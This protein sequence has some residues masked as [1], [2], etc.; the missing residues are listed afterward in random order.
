MKLTWTKPFQ[1]DYR[2]LPSKTQKIADK[3]LQFLLNSFRHPSLHTKK[4]KSSKGDVWEARITI[5]YR[6]T[7]QVQ[8]N[9]YILRR[10]GKH[11]TILF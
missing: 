6:F 7:F 5:N 9:L 3:Q 1:N 2:K 4:L 11:K 8:E 10:I